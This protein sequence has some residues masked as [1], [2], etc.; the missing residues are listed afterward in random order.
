MALALPK[1]SRPPADP[2]AAYAETLRQVQSQKSKALARL[3]DLRGQWAG[4]WSADLTEAERA[5]R[6]TRIEKEER[7]ARLALAAADDSLALAETHRQLANRASVEI[8]LAEL[9][10]ERQQV[11]T[12]ARAV[13]D[14]LP[15]VVARV[16]SVSSELQALAERDRGLA[17]AEDAE[18]VRGG[19]PGN[20]RVPAIGPGVGLFPLLSFDTDLRSTELE[21]A[22][23]KAGR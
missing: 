14:E 11:W 19:L 7:D 23:A 6:A 17:R 22:N 2:M 9:K 5:K 3:D 20:D 21:L 18:R 12:A 8:R 10:L 1:L 15:D 13:A 16:E 4:V